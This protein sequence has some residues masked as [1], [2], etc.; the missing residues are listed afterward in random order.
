M[1]TKRM[2]INFLLDTDTALY[3]PH[4]GSIGD[5]ATRGEYVRFVEISDCRNYKEQ[6]EILLLDLISWVYSKQQAGDTHG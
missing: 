1:D 2:L 6:R 4:G 5:I 3:L